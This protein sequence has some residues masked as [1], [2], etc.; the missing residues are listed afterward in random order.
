MIIA[1]PDGASSVRRRSRGG[2]GTPRDAGLKKHVG[3]RPAP[4]KSPLYAAVRRAAFCN[5]DDPC[6]AEAPIIALPRSR[7]RWITCRSLQ[8]GLS[9]S[10]VC[11]AH[12]P[13]RDA[14]PPSTLSASAPKQHC[15]NLAK[16]S[17]RERGPTH[18]TWRPESTHFSRARSFAALHVR[19][20]RPSNRCTARPMRW[21]YSRCRAPR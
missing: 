15:N 18:K 1:P 14:L 20:D 4:I 16:T 12:R 10:S 5:P 13:R 2:R 8:R 9:A 7:A 6:S 19:L 21:A 3:G 11:R 17:D